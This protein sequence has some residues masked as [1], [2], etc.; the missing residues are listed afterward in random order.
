MTLMLLEDTLTEAEQLEQIARPTVKCSWCGELIRIE[1]RELAL[2]M[3]PSCYARM[4][5]WIQGRSPGTTIGSEE[6]QPLW[7]YAAAYEHPRWQARGA[8]AREA[9][10]GGGDYFIIEDFL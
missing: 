8:V 9:G 6:W 7:D 1:G 5:I 10:H 3:C 4:V 2:A